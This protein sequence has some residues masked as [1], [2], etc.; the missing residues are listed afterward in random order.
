MGP[1]T[2]INGHVLLRDM[3]GLEIGNPTYM[4][5]CYKDR[6]WTSGVLTKALKAQMLADAKQLGLVN[7]MAHWSAW[8]Y[9][10][11]LPLFLSKSCQRTIQL[12]G[13]PHVVKMA[14]V[15]TFPQQYHTLPVVIALPSSSEEESSKEE[16]QQSSEGFE[17]PSEEEQQPQEEEEEETEQSREEQQS[18]EEDQ[19]QQNS[20]EGPEP[21]SEEEEGGEEEETEQSQ[22]GQQSE[23]EDQLQQHSSEQSEEEEDAYAMVWSSSLA[24]QNL[25]KGRIGAFHLGQLQGMKDRSRYGN[26]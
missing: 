13:G 8:I 25:Q 4:A 17:S 18:E 3:V 19:L 7:P 10:A 26:A 22:E 23:E 9:V 14:V 2:A 6:D 12:W 5:K 24:R 16:D 21:P 11:Q 20:S 1:V 15:A